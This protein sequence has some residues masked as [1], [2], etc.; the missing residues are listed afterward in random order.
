MVEA[1]LFRVAK[2]SS[3]LGETN[4]RVKKIIFNKWM[5]RWLI[6]DAD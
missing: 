1:E 2:K 4:A 5:L 3:T 6:E